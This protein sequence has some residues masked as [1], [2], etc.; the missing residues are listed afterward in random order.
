MAQYKVPQNI[1]MQDRVVGP[2]TLF[3]FLYLLAG[4]MVFY[5][6]LKTPGAIDL[7]VIGLPAAA[8]ALAFAFL[9]INDQPFSRFITSFIF[10]LLHPKKRVWHHGG[11][12]PQISL[13]QSN[14]SKTKH[15]IRRDLSATA[16]AQMAKRLDGSR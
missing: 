12:A 9:K 13:T 15:V 6:T 16:V 8:F 11:G 5:T 14:T 2:L 10:F 7:I 1:D 4:G 3:Q